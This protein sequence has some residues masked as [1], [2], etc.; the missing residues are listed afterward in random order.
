[1]LI[2]IIQEVRMKII[3]DSHEWWILW[4]VLSPILFALGCLAWIYINPYGLIFLEFIPS[5]LF[6]LWV[7][8]NE[9]FKYNCTKF[10]VLGFVITASIFLFGYNATWI[11]PTLILIAMK[12]LQYTKDEFIWSFGSMLLYGILGFIPL[13]SLIFVESLSTLNLDSL[14]LVI[15]KLF[16]L[17]LVSYFF[18][19]AVYGIL[20]HIGYKKRML[21]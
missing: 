7:L 19:G 20:L 21:S 18:K 13:F 17:F 14:S 8:N 12:L 6:G 16:G 4:G 3:K 2:F 9:N 15:S 10:V 11:A 5:A 1:M